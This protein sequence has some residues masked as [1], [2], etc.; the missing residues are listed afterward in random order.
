[1]KPPQTPQTTFKG[2]YQMCLS[3]LTNSCKLSFG[4]GNK[5]HFLNTLNEL[6]PETLRSSGV[7]EKF[8]FGFSPNFN[9]L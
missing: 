1:V 6:R 7:K 2:N 5:S 4:S 9:C 8:W 3:T